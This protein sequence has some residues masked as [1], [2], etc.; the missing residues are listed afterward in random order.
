[1]IEGDYIQLREGAQKMVAANA[2][3]AKVAAA[4]AAS[5]PRSSYMPTVAVTPMANTYRLKKV[6]SVDSKNIK[7]DKSFQDYAVIS[8]NMGDDPL[9]LSVTQHQQ[10]NGAC[11][12]VA[13]GLSNV[14]IL[15]K[16]KDSREKDGPS[17][18][19][20][21][22]LAV[23]NGVTLDRTGMNNAQ[24]SGPANGRPVSNFASKQQARATGAVYHSRR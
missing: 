15:T 23:G 9:K 16:S 14:K 24:N 5:S 22:Q 3:V 17:V 20:G 21:V 7:T 6:P 13:G 8:S 10:S 12:G 2:A 11:F 1:M 18:Q 19:S 4:A